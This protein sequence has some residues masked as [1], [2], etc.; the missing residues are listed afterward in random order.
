MV[1]VLLRGKLI[2]L[3]SIC[4]RPPAAFEGDFLRGSPSVAT[5][6][7]RSFLSLLELLA[8]HTNIKTSWD[9]TQSY[10]YSIIMIR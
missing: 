1:A 3:R 9:H 8:K 2:R 6:H 7:G 5:D 10:W 4:R